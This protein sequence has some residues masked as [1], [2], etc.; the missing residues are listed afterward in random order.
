MIV[1]RSVIHV[2]MDAFYASVEE[3]YNPSLK[4]KPIIVGGS[5]KNRGVVTTAS[6]EARKYG[7]HSAMSVFKA[8]K[9]CP[10]GIFL[11]VNMARYKEV[12]KEVHNIFKRYSKL[13]EPISI[14]EAFIDTT[15]RDP[16]FIAKKIKEDI[17]R[18]LNLTA[19]IGISTNKFLAKLASDIEKPNGLTII[20]EEEAIEFLK[21]LPIRKLWGVGPKTER[22]LHKIGIYTIGDLQDYDIKV[23]VDRFG[24]KGREMSYFSKGIDNR[25]VEI[26]ITT[27]SIG[28][29]ETFRED[30][31]S[32]EIL[33][34][35]L[36]EYSLNLS[37]KLEAKG[38]IARTITVKIKYE[39][40]SVETRSSTLYIPTN[41]YLTIYSTSINILNN[42]FNSCKK[43]RLLG[44]A[45]SN[46]IYPND[47]VQLSFPTK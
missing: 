39:D 41:D 28:E 33:I 7:V 9:L 29:E 17:K 34:Q 26:D 24:K 21:P 42:K 13:I 35:K 31:S 19:S 11:P 43:V 14:D 47:P 12:S 32:V 8:K 5:V 36:Q 46:F 45:V 20:R 6:Y 4:G 30:I 37:H 23:L 15:G 3:K 16:L 22:Q 18:E 10:K 1:S 38:Y 27:Q 40:F 25:P 44:L 2:D